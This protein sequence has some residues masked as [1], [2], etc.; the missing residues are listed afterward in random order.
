MNEGEHEHDSEDVPDEEETKTDP[1]VAEEESKATER[2]PL[3]D[4]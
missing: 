2:D 3:S 1:E 4:Y